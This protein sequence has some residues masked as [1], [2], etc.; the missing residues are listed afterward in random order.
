M[1]EVKN[2]GKDQPKAWEGNKQTVVGGLWGRRS[3]KGEEASRTSEWSGWEG[4]VKLNGE[5]LSW[6][7]CPEQGSRNR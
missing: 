4:N 2:S 3:S 5:G 6:E 7:N 1:E